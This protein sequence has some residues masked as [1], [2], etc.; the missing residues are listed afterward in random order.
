MSNYFL[1]TIFNLTI[2]S[3]IFCLE[4]PVKI[5]IGKG[6]DRIEKHDQRNWPNPYTNTTFIIPP[7]FD[8]SIQTQINSALIKAP[9][10]IFEIN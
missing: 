1:I 5:T 3:H 2:F 7:C 4:L 6:I 8:T 9:K 10:E